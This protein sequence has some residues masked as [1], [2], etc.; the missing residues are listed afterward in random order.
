MTPNHTKPRSMVFNPRQKEEEAHTQVGWQSAPE[1]G[2]TSARRP[3]CTAEVRTTG[4]KGT[5]WAAEQNIHGQ[6]TDT[7]YCLRWDTTSQ[8]G[9]RITKRVLISMNLYMGN[10]GRLSSTLVETPCRIIAFKHI[11]VGCWLMRKD[12]YMPTSGENQWRLMRIW[13]R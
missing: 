11:E 1:W 4:T 12:R 13:R 9:I 6:K 10:Q 2:P 3:C 8:A 7:C 5:P